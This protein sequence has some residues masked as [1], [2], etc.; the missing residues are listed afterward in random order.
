M[1]WKIEFLPEA[2][3]DLKRLDGDQ[4]KQVL[5]SIKKLEMDPLGYGSPLGSRSG[6]NLTGLYSIRADNRSLRVIYAIFD[7]SIQ[8]VLIIVIGKREDFAAHNEAEKRKAFYN[9]LLNFLEGSVD[10]DSFESTLA[11]ILRKRS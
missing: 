6:R 10:Q 9:E 8:I 5:K 2:R 4:R 11:R 7:T 1:S 3:D